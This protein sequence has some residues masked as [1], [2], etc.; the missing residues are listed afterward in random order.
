MWLTFMVCII[1]LSEI[2]LLEHYATRFSE[3]RVISLSFTVLSARIE[4]TESGSKLL[5]ICILAL[6]FARYRM[7]DVL[8][9]FSMPQFLHL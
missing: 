8:L 1:F 9:N 4:N 3:G 2:T 7:L 6:L 5:Y